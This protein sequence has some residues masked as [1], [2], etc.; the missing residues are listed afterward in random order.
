MSEKPPAAAPNDTRRLIA[1]IAATLAAGLVF[2][3]LNAD[4]PI[5]RNAFVYAKSARN[6]IHSGYD[7]FPVIADQW[8]S[9][10]KP[11]AFPVL[12]VF[13]DSLFGDNLGP[14]LGSYVG[15]VFFLLAACV[16]FARVNERAGI[17]RRFLPLQVALLFVSPLVS[18]QF[19]SAYPDTLFASLILVV[20]VL[21][22]KIVTDEGERSRPLRLLLFGVLGYL[23]ILTKLH[24]IVLLLACPAYLLAQRRSFL[25]RPFA[26]P[27]SRLLFIVFCTVF[28]ALLLARLEYN[29]T[30]RVVPDASLLDGGYLAYMHSVKSPGLG[31]RHALESSSGLATALILNMGLSLVFLRRAKGLAGWLAGPLCFFGTLLLGLFPFGSTDSNMRYFLPAFPLVV[32]LVTLGV[33]NT[34]SRVTRVGLLGAHFVLAG[35]LTLDFNVREINA[36]AQPFNEHVI[37]PMN[38]DRYQLDSLRLAEHLEFAKTIEG[39]NHG[40]PENSLLYWASEYYS[41]ATHG[42]AHTFGVRKDIEVK[43]VRKLEEIGPEGGPAYLF[44]FMNWRGLLRDLTD[45]F[46]VERVQGDLYRL[47][48]R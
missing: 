36:F 2:L 8:L 35:F 16:F 11:I 34:K 38:A 28:V 33:Q 18:Y 4:L 24:G 42:F 19:W 43:Y 45:R 32:V 9:F 40:I 17:S 37:K 27:K 12:L 39:L 7:P 48:P 20:Y 21:L 23:A 41:T 14:K 46:S 26:H 44:T 6:I 30:L 5:V 22:D 1:V 13:L 25:L 29:P 31:L 10:G 3:L 15:S 47:T